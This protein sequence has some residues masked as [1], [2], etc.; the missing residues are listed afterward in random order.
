MEWP[1]NEVV[2]RLG[3]YVEVFHKSFMAR[4]RGTIYYFELEA[5]ESWRRGAREMFRHNPNRRHRSADSVQGSVIADILPRYTTWTSR[6]ILAH[7][8]TT[9]PT[10]HKIAE[11]IVSRSIGSVFKGLFELGAEET[12]LEGAIE[13]TRCHRQSRC[14]QTYRLR[15]HARGLR[16][17]N[18]TA[19][20]D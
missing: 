17:G 10:T 14:R 3:G 20:N 11:D 15:V 6:T 4:G 19:H 9:A 18:I 5:V 12:G 8:N 13:K 2:I 1:I 16:L 7:G